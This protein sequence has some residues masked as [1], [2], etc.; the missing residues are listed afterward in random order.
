MDWKPGSTSANLS[1]SLCARKRIGYAHL[2]FFGPEA[3]I[4]TDQQGPYVIPVAS[5]QMTCGQQALA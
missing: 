3:D 5:E 2:E 4:L 1:G